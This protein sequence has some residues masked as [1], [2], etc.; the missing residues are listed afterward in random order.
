M[1]VYT[2]NDA[3]SNLAKILE[4]AKKTSD[5]MIQGNN[6]ELFSIQVVPPSSKYHFP[7]IDLGLTRNEIVTL[8]RESRES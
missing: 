4:D 5:V 2:F 6:G 8:V 7:K 3:C 1:N